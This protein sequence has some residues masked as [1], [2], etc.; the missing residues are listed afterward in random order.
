MLCST[1]NSHRNIIGNYLH[2][3]SKNLALYSSAYDNY[4]VIGDFNIEADSKEMSRFCDTFDLTS[5]IKEQTCYKNPDNPSCINLILT[6]KPLSSHN[7]KSSHQRCAVKNGV[8]RNFAKFT[9]KQLC[10]SPFFNKVAL[11]KR[12]WHRC[13]PVDFTKFARTTFLQNTSGRLLLY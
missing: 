5:L 2:S 13:F 1:Y 6:N 9:G 4:I 12:L 3:L 11:I 7:P 8:L 10:Q